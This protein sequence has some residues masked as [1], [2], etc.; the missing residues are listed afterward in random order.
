MAADVIAGQQHDVRDALGA[1]DTLSLE[2]AIPDPPANR[3]HTHA[4]GDG[5]LRHTDSLVR[6]RLIAHDCS[7]DRR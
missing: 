7:H 2:G 1:V 4:E 5:R 6:L 3:G